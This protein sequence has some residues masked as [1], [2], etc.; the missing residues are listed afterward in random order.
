M[1]ILKETENSAE[2]RMTIFGKS[3]MF[4]FAESGVKDE[5]YVHFLGAQLAGLAETIGCIYDQRLDG[6][7][8]YLTVTEW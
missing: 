2:L 4:T 7:W 3:W 8:I 1:E 6:E 5:E